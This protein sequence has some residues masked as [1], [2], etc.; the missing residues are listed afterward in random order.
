MKINKFYKSKLKKTPKIAVL[1]LNPHCE[2]N[3]TISEEKREII[4]E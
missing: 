2:T 3:N 1:G 4:P